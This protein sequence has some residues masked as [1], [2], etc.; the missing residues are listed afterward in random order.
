[1]ARQLHD[2]E[3]A[4]QTVH[5]VFILFGLA[6]VGPLFPFAGVFLFLMGGP[7]VWVA[8]LF[9]LIGALCL[10]RYQYETAFCLGL[11]GAVLGVLGGLAVRKELDGLF[12]LAYALWEAS[13]I[14]LPLGAWKARAREKTALLD[15]ENCLPSYPVQ[16]YSVSANTSHGEGGR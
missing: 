10:R 8:N 5:I 11:L 3:I 16:M 12:L 14:V 15:R 2:D 1:M 9:L 4:R 13:L 6:C 7:L